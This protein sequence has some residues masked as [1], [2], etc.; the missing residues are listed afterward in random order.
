MYILYTTLFLIFRLLQSKQ[1]SRTHKYKNMDDNINKILK[2][3][4]T[5]TDCM[6]K[7][8][9][10]LENLERMMMSHI[11]INKE[12]IK[13]LGE[14]RILDIQDLCDILNAS[15]RTIQRYRSEKKLPYHRIGRKTYYKE[16]DVMDFI[17]KY[18]AVS[19]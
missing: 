15:K 18:V 2:E 12:T 1:R 3:I 4:P 11:G 9:Q 14:G 19:K 5:I 8:M 10:R 7:I 6:N 16:A 13:C 17:N